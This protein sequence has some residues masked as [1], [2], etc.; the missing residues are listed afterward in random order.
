MIIADVVIRFDDIRTD[1]N[2][3]IYF[4]ARNRNLGP[5]STTLLRRQKLHRC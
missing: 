3:W 5:I 4:S 2:L 1:G